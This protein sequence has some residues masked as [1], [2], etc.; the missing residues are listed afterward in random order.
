MVSNLLHRF[1]LHKQSHGLSFF[2]WQ[3]Y[4]L[5]ICIDAYGLHPAVEDI[6]KASDMTINSAAI[7]HLYL[8]KKS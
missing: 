8:E 7:G 4:N 3:E 2:S 1:S 6:G 5:Y